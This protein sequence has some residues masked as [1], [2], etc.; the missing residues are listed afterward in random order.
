MLAAL[1]TLFILPGTQIPCCKIW[2]INEYS[3]IL[4]IYCGSYS[5][6]VSRCCMYNSVLFFSA[7]VK[8]DSAI[9]K[10]YLKQS[11]SLHTRNKLILGGITSPHHKIQVKLTLCIIKQHTVQTYWGAEVQLYT[12]LTLTVV[13]GEWSASCPSH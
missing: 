8:T 10:Q 6:S 4:S 9:L 2:Y 7:M 1:I 5:N 13:G 12:F 11:L 3:N